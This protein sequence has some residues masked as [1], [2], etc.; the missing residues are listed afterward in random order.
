[1]PEGKATQ[2]ASSRCAEHLLHRVPGRIVEAAILAEA[3]GIAGQVKDRGHGQRQRHRIAL[4]EL[5]AAQMGK[6]GRA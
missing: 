1:M 6:A 5:V 3:G 2:G 4:G